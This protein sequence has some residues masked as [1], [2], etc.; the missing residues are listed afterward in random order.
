MKFLNALSRRIWKPSRNNDVL[1]STWN[2]PIAICVIASHPNALQ[3]DAVHKHKW[4]MFH[5]PK[6]WHSM[7]L[8]FRE[9]SI[10]HT[11]RAASAQV[12][13]SRVQIRFGAVAS[14]WKQKAFQQ[15][16]LLYIPGFLRA[17]MSIKLRVWMFTEIY[18]GG[19]AARMETS[20]R[21]PEDS[22]KYF[23]VRKWLCVPF[24]SVPL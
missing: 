21:T 6:Q 11:A 3:L 22:R 23:G 20:G 19:G 8:Y 7:G 5:L 9:S 24:W 16:S 13:P 4:R 12:T 2:F 10:T 17:Q 15:M 1:K 18:H 14:S